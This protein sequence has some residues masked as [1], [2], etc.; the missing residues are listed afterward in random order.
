[1][2]IWNARVN[3]ALIREGLKGEGGKRRGRR[4]EWTR[5]REE[6]GEGRR[7]SNLESR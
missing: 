7:P 3:V 4:W 2:H 5:R 6:R 1:V